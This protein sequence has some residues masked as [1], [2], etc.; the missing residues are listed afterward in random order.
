MNKDNLTIH[1]NDIDSAYTA[2]NNRINHL[3]QF[4]MRYSEYI[5]SSHHYGGEDP[6]TMIEV[7][8]LTYIEDYP[9]TTPTEL[10]KYWGKTKGA[11]SQILNKLQSLDLI[12]KTKTPDNLKTIHLYVTEKGLRISRFHKLYDIDDINKTMSQLLEKCTSEEI[13]TF[14]KVI[15]VYNDI[16]AKDFEINSSGK[17]TKKKQKKQTEPSS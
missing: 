11:I 9:G 1:D 2:L 13:D 8:T 3:Y 6:L 10:V 4:V 5:Y 14:Y 17:G 12:V 7:H 15:S 16:I